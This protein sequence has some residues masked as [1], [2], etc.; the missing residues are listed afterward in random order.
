MIAI[1]LRAFKLL[2]QEVRGLH[3]AFYVLAFVAFLTAVVGLLRDR[4]LAHV[5]GASATLDI[6]YAAFRVPDLIFVA[7]G[8]LVSVYILIPGLARRSEEAKRDYIDTIIAG[9]FIFTILICGLAYFLAPVILPLFFPAFVINGSMPALLT[10]TR[11]MLLQPILFGFSNIFA[12]I[13]QSRKRYLLYSISPLLYNLGIIVGTVFL[14][15]RMGITGL[16]WG[17]VFGALMHAGIQV[18][19]ILDDGFFR[20]FP[21]LREPRALAETVFVSV[22]R[23]LALSM[24]EIAE[25]GLIALAGLL[26]PG[27]I[28]IF[29]FAYNLQSVPLSIIGSS[30]SVAA[31][32]TLAAALAAGRRNEFIA[33]TATAARSVV[34]WSL[35]ATALVIVLRAHLVRVILGSGAFNWTD[36][37]LTAAA[38]ALFSVSL[39]AQGLAL[40]IV[41]AYYAAGRTFV[42]F[43][44]SAATAALTI[45]FGAASIGALHTMPVVGEFASAI[46][47][48]SE[49]P[50]TSVLALAFAYTLVSIIG[51]VALLWHFEYRFAG[52]LKLVWRGWGESLLASVTCGAVAY[53]TLVAV[54]P[55]TLS[56]T[57]L[58]VFL[59]GLAGG[60]AG[61]VACTL[62]Y[63][64][65]GNRE[66]RETT[67]A[68]H[69]RLRRVSLAPTIVAAAEE[70]PIP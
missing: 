36:T 35:P 39:V 26:A 62:I 4:L 45:L 5:F 24:S 67:A 2:S 1:S 56:S 38:F 53:A 68:L 13:T 32:P 29:I 65:L 64:L 58:T 8:A 25:L 33:H 14:Y 34:F 46:L 6:Y 66:Y 18:P 19:S 70:H 20:R 7:L 47:R 41:R 54:G 61:I 63:A 23:A 12:A 16:A 31:F 69:G 51:T 11:I 55:I 44:V 40:L 49:V 21:K 9:F 3:T 37:R 17:V 10:L 42:P 43:F 52:F 50:G 60:I 48:V 22:P 15:P 59:R 57:V 30:Y 27:S 28:S